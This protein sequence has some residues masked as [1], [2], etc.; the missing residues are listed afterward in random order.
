MTN[1]IIILMCTVFM[2][3][4][5]FAQQELTL[6]TK[7]GTI[8]GVIK[9]TDRQDNK[10]IHGIAIISHG[11]NGTH[12]FGK[13]YFDTL[14]ALG[15]DV[16]T[17]DY[18][19][20]STQSKSDSN[21][22]NMSIIDETK[23]LKAI[24]KH[25]RAQK[26][27]DKNKIILIGESQGGLISALT[28]AELQKKIEALV[29]VYPA[30]CIPDDWAKRYKD[31]S[32]IPEITKIWNV[33]VGRRF[34]IELRDINVYDTIRKYQGPVLIIHGDKDNIVPISYSERAERTYTDAILKVIQNAGHG[35]TPS[36]REYVHKYLKDF[37][38]AR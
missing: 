34:F 7:A 21:T 24:V 20:G 18:P 9:R 26:D 13:D 4:N 35:F 16:Y 3:L 38:P 6:Q 17:F 15:Y 32:D 27:I 22:T 12:Y 36:Q 1:K 37:L 2:G 19:C 5:S 10:T 29:L 28:A 8:Y 30:F 31:I 33:P 14:N 11:F 25:F 23:V